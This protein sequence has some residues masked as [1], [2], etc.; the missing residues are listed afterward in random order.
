MGQAHTPTFGKVA[1]YFQG[2]P[3]DELLKHASLAGP[4][5]DNTKNTKQKSR[6]LDGLDIMILALLVQ[7]FHQ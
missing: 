3:F 5:C 7:F 4:F 6:P 2:K 1:H